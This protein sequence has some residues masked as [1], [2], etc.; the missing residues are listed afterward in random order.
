[1]FM[2]DVYAIMTAICWSSAVILFDISS[3]KMDSA[4]LNVLKNMV[5]V[6]GFIITIILLKIPIPF[7]TSSQWYI[8]L[9]S[10]AIGVGIADLLFLASLKRLGSGLS[11]VVATVYT[12]SIFIISYIL[13]DEVITIKLLTG[14][15]LVVMGIVFA[16][17]KTPKSITKA[18]LYIGI[19]LGV[20]AQILTAYSILLIKPIMVD[21]P[22]IYIALYRF[23]T[24]LFITVGFLIY[25]KGVSGLIETVSHGFNTLSIL[26]ASILGTYLSVIFWLAGFKYTLASR[27]A[28]YNQLSTILIIIMAVFFLKEKMSYKKWIGVSLSICG[29]I[30]ISIK[31]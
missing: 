31:L 3:K 24:G 19:I 13:Y 11:A 6:I 20:L 30:L 9:I 25:R 12:P 29:A 27:A 17:Y 16:T 14:G 1:M 21:N 15:M 26:A 22:I 5:G 8:L 4:Q 18:N 10:G 2:G 7:F 23:S 28:I